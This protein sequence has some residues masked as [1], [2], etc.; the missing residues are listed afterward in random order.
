MTSFLLTRFCIASPTALAPDLIKSSFAFRRSVEDSGVSSVDL[1]R[2]SKDSTVRS[3][4]GGLGSP[5]ERAKAS[6][7]R[8]ST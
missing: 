6:P 7:K 3:F 8:F 5:S 2:L 1:M 4:S